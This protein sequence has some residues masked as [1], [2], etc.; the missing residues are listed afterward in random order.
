MS[1]RDRNTLCTSEE[2]AR[3]SLK[4]ATSIHE[5]KDADFFIITV[6][7]PAYYELPN[8]EP[9]IRATKSIATI[10]KKG[11]IIVYESTVY[12]GTTEEICLPLLEEHSGL[13]SACDFYIGYSPERVSPND[14]EHTL[15][16]TPKIIS[17][18]SKK[19]LKIIEKVYKSCCDTVVPVPQIKIAEAVKILENTQRDIN[20]ALMNEFAEIM[21]AMDLNTY[22]IIKAAKTK[23]SFAPFKPGFVGGHC[24]AIDPLY[25]A[26]KA[27]RLGINHDLI[28]TSRKVNDGVTKFVS[29]E[30]IRLLINK[31]I[32]IKNCPIGVFGVTYKENIPDVR[33]SLAMKFLIE[34]KQLGFICQVH[35]PIADVKM[36][37]DKYGV[38]L[39]DFDKITNITVAIIIVGHDF[40]KK[41]GMEKFLVKMDHQKIIMDIPN[42]F[43][44]TYG[45]YDIDHYWSL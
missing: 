39:Q 36:M 6:S 1:Q 16:N 24:I 31:D 17:A 14:S 30:L 34:L 38:E 18:Q 43:I 40:Y 23:W 4:Y 44:D 10:L 21:H 15:K 9:L 12:P 33:N 8:L 29:Y 45:K 7:T 37:S 35:D 11:D 26:F 42:M 13:S 2:L 3:S 25:L 19:A 32:L 41:A 28:L 22:E 20:I 27:H 5:L